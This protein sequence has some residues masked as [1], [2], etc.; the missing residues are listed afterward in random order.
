MTEPPNESDSD[1]YPHVERIGYVEG[2]I[3]KSLSI[4]ANDGHA[5][6]TEEF[7]AVQH[8]QKLRKRGR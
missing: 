7:A 3:D 5:Y 1:E 4:F 6:S 2:R 8:E